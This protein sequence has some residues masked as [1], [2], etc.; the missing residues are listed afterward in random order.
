MSDA[1]HRRDFLKGSAVGIS[2]IAAGL[3]SASGNPADLPQADE[4][5]VKPAANYIRRPVQVV[6]IGFHGGKLALE[7]I[8]ELVDREG[9][10]GADLIALPELCRGQNQ[11][12]QE[13]LDGSTICAMQH[14]AKLHRTYIV[15]PIDRKDGIRRFNSAVLLDRTGNVACVYNKMYPVWQEECVG[16]HVLPGTRIEVHET[17]FGRVGLATCLRQ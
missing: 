11:T 8:A 2:G 10:K 7:R 6:S 17:D 14:L 5:A 9:A 3:G 12:S 15:C 4:S 16:R 13:S 1:V